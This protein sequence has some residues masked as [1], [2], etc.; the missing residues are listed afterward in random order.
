MRG[1]DSGEAEAGLPL[2]RP[3]APFVEPGQR[4]VPRQEFP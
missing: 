1:L 4:V 3:V 2:Q